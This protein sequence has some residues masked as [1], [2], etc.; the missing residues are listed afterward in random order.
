MIPVPNPPANVMRGSA[1]H[2]RVPSP[3][4]AG[5]PST[6]DQVG[7]ELNAVR[8]LAVDVP[9][10]VGD[11]RTH[12]PLLTACQYEAWREASRS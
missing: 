9:F 12:L 8:R 10:F 2:P 4:G 1:P 7:L 3:N 5:V 11:T 6:P